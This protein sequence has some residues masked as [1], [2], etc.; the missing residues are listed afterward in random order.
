MHQQGLQ[1]VADAR[2][3]GLAV[4]EQADGGIDVGGAVHVEMADALVVLDHRHPRM[5]GDEADQAF[6]AARDG[7]VDQ[8]GKLQQFQHMLARGVSHQ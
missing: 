8:V 4:D 2:P 6:A 1:R 3:R 7:Q 5:L